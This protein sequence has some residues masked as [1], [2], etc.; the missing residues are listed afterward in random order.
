MRLLVLRGSITCHAR[1]ADWQPMGSNRTLCSA[2][3]RLIKHFEEAVDESGRWEI[4]PSYYPQLA[5]KLSTSVSTLKRHIGVLVS[6][7]VIAKGTRND[8]K[9]SG[10]TGGG[11]GPAFTYVVFFLKRR[12]ARMEQTESGM[13]QIASQQ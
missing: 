3:N 8:Q 4:H 1:L 6:A 11:I 5:A 10:S 7:D 13:I 9:R 12:G 2:L